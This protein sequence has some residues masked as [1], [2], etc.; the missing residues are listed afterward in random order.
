MTN[1]GWYPDPTPRSD[2]PVVAAVV[3]G[4]IL[5]VVAMI[6]GLLI[7]QPW[8]SPQE[9]ACVAG[10]RF[11]ARTRAWRTAGDDS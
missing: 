8:R 6:A 11:R 3:V 5:I 1:P 10:F 4:A 7:T 2:G 9:K